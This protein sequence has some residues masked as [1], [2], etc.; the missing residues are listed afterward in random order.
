MN[1]RSSTP[2][3]SSKEFLRDPFLRFGESYS[4]RRL[5]LL[6]SDEF[7][8]MGGHERA[9]LVTISPKKRVENWSTALAEMHRALNHSSIPLFDLSFFANFPLFY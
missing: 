8:S 2:P 6:L 5:P 7:F 3:R 4:F 9:E 1:V